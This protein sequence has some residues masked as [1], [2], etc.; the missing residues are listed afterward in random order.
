M[1]VK[2]IILVLLMAFIGVFSCERQKQPV[3]KLESPLIGSWQFIKV[4]SCRQAV[5]YPPTTVVSRTNIQDTIGT[6]NFKDDGTGTITSYRIILCNENSF[7]WSC[8]SNQIYFTNKRGVFDTQINLFGNDTL[9]FDLRTCH[10]RYGFDI[11]YESTLL[12]FK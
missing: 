12:R 1:K 5:I 7:T 6:I 10:N 3:I 4:D 11:W 9:I 8:R 2:A